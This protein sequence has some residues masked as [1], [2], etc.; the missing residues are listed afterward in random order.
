MLV[1]NTELFLN[2]ISW[3]PDES[4]FWIIFYKKQT[5]VR[6]T[7]NLDACEGKTCVNGSC[8]KK[9]KAMDNFVQVVLNVING[10]ASFVFVFWLY[11]LV[12][13]PSKSICCKNI[14]NI[15]TSPTLHY[16][17]ISTKNKRR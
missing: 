14:Q 5:N 17:T 4:N 12:F 8:D 9:F 13:P 6:L 11:F 2:D 16:Q 15:S 10:R 3:K 1:C 7:V